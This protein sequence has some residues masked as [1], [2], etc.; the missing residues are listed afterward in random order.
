MSNSKGKKL[1][2]IRHAHREILDRTSDH[3]LSEKGVRQS[4]ILK[5]QL[6]SKYSLHHSV[7][8]SSPKSR[9]IETLTPLAESIGKQILIHKL[10]DEKNQSETEGEF[11]GRIHQFLEEWKKSET[12][13]TL[14][15]SHGDWLP[16][17]VYHLTSTYADFEKGEWAEIIFDQTQSLLRFRD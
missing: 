16:I 10:L 8:Y 11:R 4:L 3:G 9:C 17:A 2:F 15:C 12:S 13:L 7:L 5:D 14:V 1:I 6:C